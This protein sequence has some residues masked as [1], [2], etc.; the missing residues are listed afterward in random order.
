MRNLNFN[1]LAWKA[2]KHGEEYGYT[3]TD[4]YYNDIIEWLKTGKKLYTVKGDKITT[5][6][7]EMPNVVHNVI[8]EFTHETKMVMWY[9]RKSNEFVI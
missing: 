8:V 2:P 7:M 3:P 1:E 6:R 4:E 9:F 5:V